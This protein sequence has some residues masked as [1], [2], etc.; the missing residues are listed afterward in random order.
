MCPVQ[1]QGVVHTKKYPFCGWEYVQLVPP[2]FP[3]PIISQGS[4][5]V[6]VFFVGTLTFFYFPTLFEQ[7][8]HHLTF[9]SRTFHETPL[10]LSEAAAALDP[11]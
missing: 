2:P 8:K 4:F 3:A 1:S 10:R 9:S 5:F 11:P 6:L 7:L